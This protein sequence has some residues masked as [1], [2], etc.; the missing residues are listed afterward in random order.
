MGVM[1]DTGP[2]A[3][4][5][6]GP[7]AAH[8]GAADGEAESVRQLSGQ[9][10]VRL[11]RL[12]RMI[13]AGA[14]GGA[15]SSGPPVAPGPGG[16]AEPAWRRETRGEQRWAV[17]ASIM[18][19]LV[20]QCLLPDR[21]SFRPHWVLPVLAGALLIGTIAANPVRMEAGSRRLRLMS[22]L[23]V[24]VISVA[25]AF[26]AAELVGGLVHG[27]E[28]ADAGAL[29]MTGGGIWITNI[30]VFALWYWEWDRGGPA[31]RAAGTHPYPDFLFPQMQ[32]P[33]MAP[34]HWEPGFLD[35]LY[36]AFTNAT[37][38]SPTDVLPMS[39][40]AKML[41]TGQSLVSLVTVALVVARA[42]N[43][44]K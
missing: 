2:V 9:L 44:L 32:L 19:A 11:D 3:G 41:M 7:A 20:V 31:C 23:L 14:S 5:N 8:G 40:W 27:S 25:N 12:E 21:L 38:F 29:L 4:L 15:P 36:L 35:Y 1:G 33:D 30:I 37:A 26:S 43:I 22:L 17:T 10:R 34:P 18:A 16:T 24:A 42:V 6:G 39:R 13:A 28:G